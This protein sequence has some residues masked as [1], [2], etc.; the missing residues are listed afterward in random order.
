MRRAEIRRKFDEIVAFA[1]IEKFLDTPVKRYSSGMYVRLAFAVAAH[2]EQDILLVDEVLAVGDAAFQKKC[3][4]KMGE[5]ARDGR[6]I[7]LVSH[8]LVAIEQLCTT[9]H[10][11]RGWA[12]W[13][14]PVRRPRSSSATTR[15]SRRRPRG[16]SIRRG[17]GDGTVELLSYTVADGSGRSFPPPVTGEDV[18]DPRP[19][20]AQHADH[21][22]GRRGLRLVARRGP[23]HQRRHRRTSGSS[24]SRC[25]RASRRSRSTLARSLTCPARIG[26][27]SGSTAQ[28]GT[29]TLTSRTRSPSRSARARC[30][31]PA[32]SIGR[33]GASTPGSK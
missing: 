13:P 6:T 22:T 14:W 30:T 20:D 17:H 12:E 11:A 15:A 3:L 4:A 8:N 27:T 33:S 18:A 16:P 21:P 1:E 32:R 19:D 26:S 9:A 5:V 7:V 2:L 23:A 28:A 31:A 25:R 10:L 29:S 24:S